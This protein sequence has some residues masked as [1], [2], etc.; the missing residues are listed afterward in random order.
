MLRSYYNTHNL[1]TIQA[2]IKR[3]APP[4]ENDTDA[5]ISAVSRLTAFEPDDKLTPIEIGKVA[6]AMLRVETGARKI[7]LSLVQSEWEAIYWRS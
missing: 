7:P 1:K 2:I 3:W 4:S 6:W 5:Y